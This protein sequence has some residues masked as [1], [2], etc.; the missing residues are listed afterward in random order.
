MNV[1]K[2]KNSIG[3]TIFITLKNKYH[4]EGELISVDEENSCL[5]MVDRFTDEVDIDFNSISSIVIKNGR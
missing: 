5:T 1:E 2:L 4:Y 3:K